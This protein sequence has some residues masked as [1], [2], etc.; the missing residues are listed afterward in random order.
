MYDA[1]IKFFIDRIKQYE[2]V[3][4][5]K[6][7]ELFN[8]D[9]RVEK[10]SQYFNRSYPTIKRAILKMNKDYRYKIADI[11]F[12]SKSGIKWLCENCFKQKYIEIL[13]K[14]K[15]ELTEKYIQAGYIYDNFFEK[16]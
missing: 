5:I 4:G 14:Y 8:E 9:I 1:D 6:S 3:L 16:N 12:I 13:E 2:K 7:K 15:M 10:L 11:N